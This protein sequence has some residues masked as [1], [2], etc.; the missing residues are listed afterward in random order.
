MFNLRSYH[1]WACGKSFDISDGVICHP[2]CGVKCP[3][4]GSYLTSEYPG[5]L[6]RGIKSLFGRKSNR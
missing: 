4:C 6:I 3:R 1:C 2:P 5:F